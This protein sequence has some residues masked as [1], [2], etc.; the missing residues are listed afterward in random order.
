MKQIRHVFLFIGLLIGFFSCKQEKENSDLFFEKIRTNKKN[1]EIFMRAMPKGGDL[2]HHFAGSIYPETILKWAIKDNLYLDLSN[3]TIN[4]EKPKQN[5]IELKNITSRPDYESLKNKILQWWSVRDYTPDFYPSHSLFFETFTKFIQIVPKNHPEGLLEIKNRAKLENVSYIETM[6]VPIQSLIQTDYLSSFN[7]KLRQDALTQNKDIILQDL[8]MMYQDFIKNGA[9]NEAV[10]YNKKIIEDN[11]YK[12]QIDDS[13]F[14]LRYQNYVIRTNPPVDVFE[15]LVLGFM[16]AE[17]SS[18]VV[19]VNIVAPEDNEVAMNDY[20]LHMIMFEFCHKKFPNVKY[21]LH[22]GE[23][24]HNLALPEQLSDHI[25]M[26]LE[27]AG[28]NRI[29]HGVDIASETNAPKLLNF[30]KEQHI[31]IEINLTSNEFILNVKN[32][33]HPI[34]LYFNNKIPIVI[35]TDDAGIL[36]TDLTTQFVELAWRYPHFKYSDIKQFIYNSLEYCFIEEP[37]LKKRLI[38]DLN[39]RFTI[40]EENI[41]KDFQ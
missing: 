11:H 19:G 28:A 5:F 4:H 3:Y 2:H 17:K 41:K 6:F 23:L 33:N 9:E 27:I 20:W 31:P 26:A 10:E 40:F 34:E 29:G 18:L 37:T 22:A 35:S 14:S 15:S 8:E 16:S 32:E 25:K 39:Q 30:M 21:A 7:Q 38:Q 36:R 1:I 13:N 12:Y 24:T